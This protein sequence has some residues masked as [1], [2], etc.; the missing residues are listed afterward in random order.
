MILRIKQLILII[1]V[2]FLLS[3]A[4][5]LSPLALELRIAACDVGQ[6]DAI[7]I[8]YGQRHILIDSGR[9]NEVLDCLRQE[10][11]WGN[12][13]IDVA[14]ITHWDEDHIGG[15]ASILEEYEISNWLFNPTV[16]DTKTAQNLLSQIKTSRFQPVMGDE[17]FFPGMRLRVLWSEK[18][19][20]LPQVSRGSDQNT[21][22]IAVVIETESFGFFGTGDLECPEQLAI[23]D[24]GLLNNPQIIKIAHHG[25]KSGICAELLQ[26]LRPEVGIVSVGEGNSYGH[27]HTE[28][29]HNLHTFGVFLRRTDQIGKIVLE[30]LPS[31]AGVGLFKTP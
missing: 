25:A 10:T 4:W 22:S 27:P 21:R 2:F 5:K 6:G 20:S 9:N 31:M 17:I 23:V 12:K 26:R 30:W 3:G 28:T 8:R 18:T 19:P 1:G 7:L 15:F 13:T 16:G 29:I 11:F 24:S 14:V